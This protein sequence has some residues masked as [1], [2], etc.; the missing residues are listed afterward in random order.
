MNLE[1]NDEM[2]EDSFLL[3]VFILIMEIKKFRDLI[4]CRVINCSSVYG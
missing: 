4:R 1:A 3:E 2:D